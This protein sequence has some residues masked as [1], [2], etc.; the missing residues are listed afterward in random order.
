MSARGRICVYDWAGRICKSAHCALIV[1]EHQ[2]GP[3]IV[4]QCRQLLIAEEVLERATRLDFSAAEDK[5][6]PGS[7]EQHARR[8]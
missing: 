3:D 1:V 5:D 8:G 4:S 6:K 7:S 2:C